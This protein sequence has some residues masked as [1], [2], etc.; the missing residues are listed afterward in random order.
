MRILPLSTIDD[1][2]TILQEVLRIRKYLEQNPIRNLFYIKEDYEDDVVSYDVTKVEI[3]SGLDVTIA[4]DDVIIFANG[5]IAIVDS[6]GAEYVTIQSD[7]VQPFRGEKGDNGANGIGISAITKTGTAGLVDTYTI[8]FTNGS[9][10]TFT[11]TNGKDGEDGTDGVDGQNGE[12]C[13]FFTSD[14]DFYDVEP[15]DPFPTITFSDINDSYFNPKAGDCIVFSN[16]IV[17][18]VE[19]VDIPNDE[20]VIAKTGVSIKGANGTN[21]TN[22]VGVPTGGTD[23]QVLTKDGSTDY[24]T[25]WTTPSSGGGTI[26]FGENLITNPT[27]EINQRGNTSITT[28]STAGYTVDRWYG[29]VGAKFQFASG[30]NTLYEGTI[31]QFVDKIKLYGIGPKYIIAG[32][33]INNSFST[34]VDIS[35]GYKPTSNP[36][37]SMT[38]INSTPITKVENNILQIFNIYEVWIHNPD[39][40]K[41]SITK[42][43]TLACY[44]SGAF[45]YAVDKYSLTDLQDLVVP[46][47]IDYNVELEKCKYYYQAPYY[48]EG[49]IGF[50]QNAADTN[51]ATY[52]GSIPIQYMRIDP[53]K[54]NISATMTVVRGDYTVASR[55]SSTSSIIY[56]TRNPYRRYAYVEFMWTDTSAGVGLRSVLGTFTVRLDAEIYP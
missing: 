47:V 1:N 17:V 53:T 27:F 28:L 45:I 11:V 34:N 26:I 12:P 56:I 25:K 2:R 43:D 8:T 31:S 24:Q 51:T 7:S 48:A 19:S 5:Y 52:K 33:K 14:L 18:Q 37:V 54:S 49:A 29:D 36:Y 10:T 42:T 6:V 20:I 16:G 22:G 13:R 41:F 40:Y 4:A 35:L 21:G 30:T 3:N 32:I 50:S 23:G 44:L 38:P 9:T 55:S 46:C 39:Y 15:F